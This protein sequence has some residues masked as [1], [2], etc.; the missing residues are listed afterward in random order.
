MLQDFVDFEEYDA[1]LVT[2]GCPANFHA[3]FVQ[4]Y[5]VRKVADEEK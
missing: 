5:Y 2:G 1:T 4:M 3:S